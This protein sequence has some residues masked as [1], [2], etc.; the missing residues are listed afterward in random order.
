MCMHTCT[1][2]HLYTPSCQLH[3]STGTQVSR[4]PSFHTKFG[5]QHSFSYQASTTWNQLPASLHY[6]FCITSFKSF[7]ENLS[8]TDRFFYSTALRYV[9]VC[10]CACVCMWLNPDVL[11][12][13]HHHHLSLNREGHLGTTDD[14]TT[15]L[16]ILCP[17]AKF[18]SAWGY[19][20]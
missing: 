17:C 16:R 18:V 1:H 19:C 20:R 7:P 4:I 2:L 8:F 3:S 11:I 5:G 12:L 13:C 10:V 14:F 6:A 9:H 15:W